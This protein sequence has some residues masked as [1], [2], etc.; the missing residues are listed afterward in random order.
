MLQK[1]GFGLPTAGTRNRRPANGEM[2]IQQQTAFF[3]AEWRVSPQEDSLTLG[4]KT[5]RLEPRA[6]EVLVY[7]ASRPGDVVTRAELEETV[8]RGG[9][10]GY[11]A[12]TNTVIKL[13]K[14]LG[15]NARNPSF[16]ATVP[17][18]GYQLIAPVRRVPAKG[19]G[20]PPPD[21]IAEA[22][23]TSPGNRMSDRA[24]VGLMILSLIHISEPTR[25]LTQSRMPS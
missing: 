17:K 8:W 13:R 18:R 22:N 14:A 23:R 25:Q 12:V 15:D 4:D 1:A 5:V 2:D 9:L 20:Q 19:G 21:D 6:M 10:V 3:I 16:I 24:R 7:L 11:D